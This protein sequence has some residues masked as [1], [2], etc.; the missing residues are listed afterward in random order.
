MQSAI[1]IIYI[2]FHILIGFLGSGMMRNQ[3]IGR[4]K[5]PQ[6]PTVYQCEICRLNVTDGCEF[7][8]HIENNHMDVVE[9]N[10]LLSLKTNILQSEEGNSQ[11][12]KT[13]LSKPPY[14]SAQ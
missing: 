10:V 5:Q 7:I 11:Y 9:K 1:G 8:T 6:T 4:P 2:I 14:S 12:E 13:Y 3:S